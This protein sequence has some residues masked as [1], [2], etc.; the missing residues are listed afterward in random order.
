MLKRIVGMLLAIALVIP[1]SFAGAAGSEDDSFLCLFHNFFGY[2]NPVG[3]K[4]LPDGFGIQRSDR[5]DR[6]GAVYDADVRHGEV[7]EVG[8]L[9]EP[10]LRFGQLV[11]SGKLHISFDFRVSDITARRALIAFYDGRADDDPAYEQSNPDSWATTKYSNTVFLNPAYDGKVAY[12]YGNLGNWLI[13][14]NEEMIL[15]NDS[16][17]RMDLL[18]D[19][20]ANTAYYYLDGV[21]INP[22]NPGLPKGSMGQGF[23]ALLFRVE[24]KDGTSGTADAFC[25]DNV[26]VRTYASE[27]P[28][29]CRPAK[30]I[31]SPLSDEMSFVL[32]EPLTTAVTED[33]IVFTDANGTETA[34]T[35]T[36]GGT[37]SFAIRTRGLAPDSEYRLRLTGVTGALTGTAASAETA[38]ATAPSDG[39]VFLDDF[40]Q[41]T[42]SAE[43][44]EVWSSSEPE[45][46][47]LSDAGR[48]GAALLLENNGDGPALSVDFVKPADSDIL[49]IELYLNSTGSY[50]IGLA[51]ADGGFRNVARIE[52]GSEISIYRSTDDTDLVQ[53]GCALLRNEWAKLKIR[54]NR[55]DGTIMVADNKTSD[56]VSYSGDLGAVSGLILNYERNFSAEILMDDIR[57]SDAENE[58]DDNEF[59]RAEYTASGAEFSGAGFSGRT[60]L[61][62]GVCLECAVVD[63]TDPNYYVVTPSNGTI[64]IDV[65]G[66]F[67]PDTANRQNIIITITYLDYGY[68]WFYLKYSGIGGVTETESVCLEN[69]CLEKSYTFTLH[70]MYFENSMDGYDIQV[71][72]T[73]RTTDHIRYASNDRTYSKYPVYI[74]GISGGTDGT[75]APVAVTVASENTGNIFYDDSP[76]VF[77]ISYCN[78]T[79]TGRTVDVEYRVCGYSFDAE[80]RAAELSSRTVSYT[81]DGGENINEKFTYLP[82]KYGLYSL[83]IVISGNGISDYLSVPF[84]KCAGNTVQNYGMGTSAHFTRYGNAD[85]GLSLLKKA[86]MGLVRDDF[87]WQHY[88]AVK[89]VKTLNERQRLLLEAAEKY[90][91]K[92]LPIITGNNR[93]YSASGTSSGFVAEETLPEFAEFVKSILS[94]EL[95]Q[96]VEM[97][98]V[99]N[100]PDLVGT[101]DGTA[102]ADVSERGRIYE[103][104]LETAYNAA[105]E[106]RPDIKVGAFSLSGG[107]TSAG[108]K[109]FTD[110]ALDA[111]DGEQYF[112]NFTMHPYLSNEDPEIGSNGRDSADPNTYLAYQ[113]NYYRALLGGT[114]LYNHVTQEDEPVTGALTGNTYHMDDS[115]PFWHTEFGYSTALEGCG[116]ICVGNEYDQAINLLAHYNSIKVNNFEDKVWFYDFADDGLRMNEK[117]HNFGILHSHEYSVPYAAKYAYLALSFLNK[118]T[119]GATGCEEIFS[120]N[121]SFV[122]KYTCADRE[123]YLFRS[124]AGAQT[125]AASALELGDDITYY[126]MLGN[127]LPEASVKQG[128]DYYLNHEPFWAVTDASSES[129]SAGNGMAELYILDA[130][131]EIIPDGDSIDPDETIGIKL[132]LGRFESPQRYTVLAAAY[133]DDRLI[134][135]S[136]PEKEGLTEAGGESRLYSAG[137]SVGEADE[138]KVFVLD[139]LGSMEPIGNEVRR[140]VS[141]EK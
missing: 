52:S 80:Q 40:E 130:D 141:A 28:I 74:R 77:D 109:A 126:D 115:A 135:F 101:V 89:G 72:T 11:S 60:I 137:L 132:V 50:S 19:I 21:C 51:Q 4:V 57:V 93:Y 79:E 123:V 46:L 49:E 15:E 107:I 39:T 71:R 66:D 56:T 127:E 97:I 88:E 83:E 65:D 61:P 1:T 117:E 2:N 70:D 95:F 31:L 35:L 63:P 64:N 10:T 36:Q 27:V 38:V 102:T 124:T 14:T 20:D 34:Y 134:S 53:S 9:G 68:G 96:E 32:S 85:E 114:S 18:I 87:E 120:E 45:N 13:E 133:K 5:A 136:V 78:M 105:R 37:D 58:V 29:V 12:Y 62:A 112:D 55:A 92:V 59:M 103:R 106:V 22:N 48:A 8:H 94:E 128:G 76:A 75:A 111:M 23:K 43:L 82:D 100:E 99:W 125:V 116:T 47:Q 25:F 113:I 91:V 108:R 6:V 7:L 90:N 138:V 26:S 122:T 84:S 73:T 121:Y 41:Y 104:I 24:S 42:S 110:A 67:K 30:E 129:G 81:L 16:W 3:S 131:G 86:G 54:I 118:L 33:N 69:T 140:Y 119:A 17:Y 139:S 98:E 44:S